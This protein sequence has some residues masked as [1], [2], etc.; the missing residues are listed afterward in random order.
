[1][2]YSSSTEVV[3]AFWSEV[4]K[5][6]N[7][8]KIDDFVV[9]DFVITSGGERIEGRENFKAWVR[10]FL[11]GIDDS[12]SM[13]SRPSRTRTAAGSHHGGG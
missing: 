1:M 11:D 3:E 9:E 4:W 6:R 12:G 10:D 13:S 7:P 8:D 2:G 5:A